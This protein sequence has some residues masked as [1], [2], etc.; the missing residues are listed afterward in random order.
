MR[1]VH[2]DQHPQQGG[3][4]RHR[5]HQGREPRTY[6]DHTNCQR[7]RQ[8][9]MVAGERPVARLGTRCEGRDHWQ[10]TTRTFLVDKEFDRL[11]QSVG[12]NGPGGRHC[13]PGQAPHVTAAQGGP[14]D[15]GQQQAQEQQS[16]LTRRFQ[17]GLGPRRPVRHASGQGT[18][19]PRREARR[20]VHRFIRAQCAAGRQPNHSRCPRPGRRD[21][22]RQP[23]A[24]PVPLDRFHAAHGRNTAGRVPWPNGSPVPR[25]S[26]GLTGTG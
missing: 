6:Q 11:T 21:R 13:H 18:V 19:G 7:D 20:D 22:H 14:A 16:T 25:R 9:G 5:Q 3:Q 8:G 26:S 2:S 17:G 1:I 12:D 15:P 4:P 10:G 24:P 23:S